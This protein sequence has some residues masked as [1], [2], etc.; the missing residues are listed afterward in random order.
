V[1]DQ[2]DDEVKNEN[3]YMILVWFGVVE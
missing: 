2:N 1:G 3:F